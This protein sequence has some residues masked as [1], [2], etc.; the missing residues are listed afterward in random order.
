MRIAA[1]NALFAIPAARLGLAYPFNSLRHLVA[2]AGPAAAKELLFTGRR[3]A[4][5]D[6]HEMGLVNKVCPA[7]AVNGDV[8]EIASAIAENAPLTIRCAKAVIDDAAAWPGAARRKDIEDL[9]T[10][11]YTSEDYKEGRAA[12]L[13][14][15]KPVFTG[16]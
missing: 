14:K 12:F 4:A 13:E 3:V 9:A 1:E 11:C 5:P 6:A 7:E 10:A 16:R 8:A 2:V 15:R